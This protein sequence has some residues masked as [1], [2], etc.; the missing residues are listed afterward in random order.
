M[1]T[2]NYHRFVL[3]SAF[4]NFL[5]FLHVH[6]WFSVFITEK[7]TTTTETRVKCKV[8]TKDNTRGK[9]KVNTK[10]NTK[11]KIETKVT[12]ET[13]TETNNKTT[14]IDDDLATMTST[15]NRRSHEWV[16]LF[17][18][19]STLESGTAA[20]IPRIFVL[21]HCFTSLTIFLFYN[22]FTDHNYWPS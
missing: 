6:F 7:V 11:V 18:S 5:S 2:I 14:V 9:T 10:D 20:V 13:I 19:L 17:L 4:F 16:S 22:T 21:N 1:I 3:K 12:K 15:M 8:K